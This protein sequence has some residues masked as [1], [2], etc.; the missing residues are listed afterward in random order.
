[1]GRETGV[2]VMLSLSLNAQEEW[3]VGREGFKFPTNKKL[4]IAEDVKPKLSLL[5]PSLNSQ[6]HSRESNRALDSSNFPRFSFSEVCTWKN[7]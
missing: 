5:R 2:V 6:K 3:K 4:A 1:M 7:R